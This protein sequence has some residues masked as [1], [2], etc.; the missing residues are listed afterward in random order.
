MEVVLKHFVFLT[1]QNRLE[2]GHRKT[3]NV[4]LAFLRVHGHAAK[5]AFRVYKTCFHFIIIPPG[6]LSDGHETSTYLARAIGIHPVSPD[7]SLWH[8]QSWRLPDS[9]GGEIHTCRVSAIPWGMTDSYYAPIWQ[10]GAAW[11]NSADSQS[12]G[13]VGRFLFV[14]VCSWSWTIFVLRDDASVRL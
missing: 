11:C 13:L 14:R 5:Q 9:V 12:W 4:V 8:I 2:L 1:D 6:L 7:W 3:W 10:T